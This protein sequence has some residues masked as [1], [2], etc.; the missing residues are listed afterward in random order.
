VANFSQVP[1]WSAVIFGATSALFVLWLKKEAS[2]FLKEDPLQ[3]FA[4]HTG[5]GFIGM[6]LTGLLARFVTHV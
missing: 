4:V 2:I 5:G 3:V 6:L 1:V